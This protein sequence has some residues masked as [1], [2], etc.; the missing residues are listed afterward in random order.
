MRAP[1]AALLCSLCVACAHGPAPAEDPARLP[2]LDLPA[3]GPEPFAPGDLEGKVVLVSFFATWCFP[4]LSDLPTL[5]ALQREHGAQGLQVVAIGVDREGRKVLEP[6]AY[7]Y[8]PPFPVLVA[9]ES[10]RTGQTRFGAVQAVPQGMLFGR[11]GRL[12]SAWRGPLSA[13]VLAGEV[14]RLLQ[15]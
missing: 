15:R 10:L 1:A 14:R 3:V 12:V 7:S 2:A 9:D 4:C 11:D 5:Q 8:K 13:E 6:F